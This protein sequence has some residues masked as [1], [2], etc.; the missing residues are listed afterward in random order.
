MTKINE[1]HRDWEKR[2]KTVSICR[3]VYLK[4][5]LAE[6]KEFGGGKNH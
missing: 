2:T 6:N 4:T 5:T 1:M 3:H